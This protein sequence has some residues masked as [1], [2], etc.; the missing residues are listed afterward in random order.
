MGRGA[1]DLHRTQITL[2]WQEMETGEIKRCRI[3]PAT[4]DAVRQ[5]LGQFEGRDEH[6][7]LEATTGWRF[8]VEEM[9]AVGIT[10]HLAEPAETSARRGPKRRAKTTA[11]I[12]TS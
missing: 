10:P 9:R 2:R 4:R 5:W 6:L 11:R 12:A 7:A 3:M 1:L 8:V